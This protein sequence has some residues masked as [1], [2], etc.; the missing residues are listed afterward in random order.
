MGTLSDQDYG[1]DR[2]A[3][4]SDGTGGALGG[5]SPRLIGR[6]RRQKIFFYQEDRQEAR[7]C[8]LLQVLLPVNSSLTCS[9]ETLICGMKLIALPY[10]LVHLSFLYVD[11]LETVIHDLGLA[12]GAS[13]HPQFSPMTETHGFS[14]PLTYF[15]VCILVC[16]YCRRA[17]GVFKE[18]GKD[19]FV[20]ELD[21]RV[22][23][24]HTFAIKA[25]TKCSDLPKKD[26]L[27]DDGPEIQDALS[28][29]I[30][31]VEAYE[32]G[33]LQTLLGIDTKE[34]LK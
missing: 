29:F 14:L 3:D 7:R 27:T 25:Q 9:L 15:P 20:V 13:R 34:D 2:L 1:S 17:K 23:F 30:D 10:F 11:L 32:S 16:R 24:T 21:Q 8:H 5:G 22:P 6:F 18:L 28:E 33:K 4:R 31:T 19:P 26:L 12:I